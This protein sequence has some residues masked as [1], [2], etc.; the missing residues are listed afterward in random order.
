MRT[1]NGELKLG[2]FESVLLVVGGDGTGGEL[3]SDG[4]SGRGVLLFAVKGD[5]VRSLA[6]GEFVGVTVD[7]CESFDTRDAF[8]GCDRSPLGR[9]LGSGAA[10]IYVMPVSPIS[11]M[12]ELS[13]DI[14]A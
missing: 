9:P 4:E 3:P 1:L 8:D 14:L 10:G 12:M 2:G 6:L 11:D 5:T 13:V 7:A